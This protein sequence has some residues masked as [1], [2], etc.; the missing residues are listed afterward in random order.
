MESDESACT[1]KIFS[2]CLEFILW[3]HILMQIMQ[4]GASAEKDLINA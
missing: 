2:E 1:L 3:N 4:R